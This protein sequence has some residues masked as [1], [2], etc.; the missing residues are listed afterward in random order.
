MPCP[1]DGAP[2]ASIALGVETIERCTRCRGVWVRR[3]ALEALVGAPVV[4][5]PLGLAIAGVGAAS[6]SCPTCGRH[7]EE[8]E[9]RDAPGKE[10]LVCRDCARVFVD[11]DT[12]GLLRE[13]RDRLAVRRGRA[14]ERGTQTREADDDE[15]DAPTNSPSPEGDLRDHGLERPVFS[16]G[17][18]R[19]LAVLAVTALLGWLFAQTLFG[20]TVAFFVRI[21]FHELG[22]ALVAWCTG[23]SAL[24]LPF[25]WTSWSFERSSILVAMELLFSVLL[26]IWGVREKKPIAVVVAVAMGSVFTLGLLT[27][28]TDSEPWLVAGGM[29]GEALL[30]AIAL[31]AFHA[32]L[33]ARAR[34]DF[35]RW[36][37]AML[38]ILAVVSVGPHFLSIASGD[39]P[40]P[41]GSFVSGRQGDGDLERLI[42]DYGWPHASLR[43][44]FGRLGLLTLLI[45]LLPHPI[46]LGARA[47]ASRR[48]G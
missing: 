6:A 12:L 35:V 22:H 15:V 39:A 8:E 2:F 33:P 46:V 20:E 38:A 11:E 3:G 36:P 18:M 19:E 37:L 45:G 25:G 4:S 29:I 34:W 44:L 47:L 32:P 27:P 7:L 13:A 21:Q 5:R 26:A 16:P 10:L 31:L 42:A 9:S 23:R 30:P 1:R 14:H 48:R 28:L 24:P 43:P 17:P 41:M 40:L